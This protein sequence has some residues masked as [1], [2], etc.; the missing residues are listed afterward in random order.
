MLSIPE[1]SDSKIPLSEMSDPKKVIYRNVGLTN[2]PF[3]NVRLKNCQ[4]QK[5]QTFG[6]SFSE[7]SDLRTV[8]LRNV[9]FQRLLRQTHV[10][11]QKKFSFKRFKRGSIEKVLLM[12]D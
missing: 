11:E 5:C 4:F 6:L 1:M 10:H 2:I 8:T 9:R 7:M 3:R 12:K